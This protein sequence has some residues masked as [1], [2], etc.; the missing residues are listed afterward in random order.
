MDN[1]DEMKRRYEEM[2]QQIEEIKKFD[3]EGTIQKMMWLLHEMKA[4]RDRIQKIDFQ[5]ITLGDLEEF[6]EDVGY[7]FDEYVTS[8]EEEYWY[9]PGDEDFCLFC[10]THREDTKKKKWFDILEVEE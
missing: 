1:L 9:L 6:I 7:I 3:L 5:K 4:E 2:K 10:G 8:L